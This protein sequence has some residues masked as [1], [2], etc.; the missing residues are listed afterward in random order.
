L[1]ALQYISAILN[2]IYLSEADVSLLIFQVSELQRHVILVKKRVAWT[3]PTQHAKGHFTASITWQT[4]QSI[5]WAVDRLLQFTFEEWRAA[6]MA[7]WPVASSQ[8]TIHRTSSPGWL[9]AKYIYCIFTGQLVKK[10]SK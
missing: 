4:M 7:Q 1:I 5:Q 10:S 9:W 8:R 6:V 2:H 3:A